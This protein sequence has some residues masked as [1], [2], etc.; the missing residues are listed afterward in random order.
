MSSYGNSFS[1]STNGSLMT[2]CRALLVDDCRTTNRWFVD[3]TDSVVEQRNQHLGELR[4][5]GVDS[6]EIPK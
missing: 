4:L 6:K 3:F 5:I 2:G 1:E